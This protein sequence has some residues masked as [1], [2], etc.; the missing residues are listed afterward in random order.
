MKEQPKIFALFSVKKGSEIWYRKGFFLTELESNEFKKRHNMKTERILITENARFFAK[1][2]SDAFRKNRF[3]IKGS[4]RF[5]MTTRQINWFKKLDVSD[6][7]TDPS[8][9]A[10]KLRKECDKETN[11]IK[12]LKEKE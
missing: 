4:E 9:L 1:A 10:A 2:F 11:I 7:P 3:Y 5:V 6:Y 8:A 12:K